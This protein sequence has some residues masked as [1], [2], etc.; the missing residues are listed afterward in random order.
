[1]GFQHARYAS[2]V[3]TGANAGDQHVQPLGEVGQDFLRRGAGVDV[4]VGGVFKLLRHPRVGGL[5]LQL[6]GAGDGAFHAFFFR[7]QIK[8]CAIGQHQAA[9]FDAHAVGH[10]Q[11]QFVALDR[12]HQRQANASVARG[13]LDDGA[14]G[15]QRAGFFGVLD[16]GQCNAVFDGAAGVAALGLDPD[17][18]IRAKQAVDT[19]VGRVADGLQNVVEFHGGVS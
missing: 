9:A 12:S 5:R 6:F 17:V 10:H 7:C 4:G 14:A 1:M 19:H 8:L 2:Q 3:A 13:R 11:N 15:L 18:G 16:H